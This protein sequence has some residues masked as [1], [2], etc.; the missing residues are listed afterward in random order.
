MTDRDIRLAAVI[1]GGLHSSSAS[2][3]DAALREISSLLGI[4]VWYPSK[5]FVSVEATSTK[6]Q[7]PETQF[8]HPL[9]SPV[10]E[11]TGLGLG[12]ESSEQSDDLGL[13]KPTKPLPLP[14]SSPPFV[15]PVVE[16][17]RRE[18]AGRIKCALCG[19]VSP[20]QITHG[21]HMAEKHSPP[22]EE[23]AP[24]PAPSAPPIQVRSE[25]EFC[26]EMVRA[27]DLTSHI[28]F[29]HPVHGPE[30]HV[31]R[32][33][34]ESPNGTTIRG[35]CFCGE[36]RTDPATPSIVP[37]GKIARCPRC[38]TRLTKDRNGWWCDTCHSGVDLRPVETSA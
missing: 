17:K 31:H 7:E 15:Q 20:G 33:K 26:H 10:E 5:T 12:T 16:R 27:T 3:K 13:K 19:N 35:E 21:R 11:D 22:K 9:L 37:G 28:H 32:W 18:G 6:I 29:A 36:T 24:A 2:A 23:V 30:R 14:P 4:P 1:N 38:R 34:M 8:S 25:C